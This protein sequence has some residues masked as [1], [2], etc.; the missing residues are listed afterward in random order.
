[1]CGLAGMLVQTLRPVVC[2]GKIAASLGELEF[3][4]GDVDIEYPGKGVEDTQQI[5]KTIVNPTN[6]G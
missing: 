3:P 1:M 4:G 6:S 5:L 2:A